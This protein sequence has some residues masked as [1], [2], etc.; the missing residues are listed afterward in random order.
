[1]LSTVKP[2]IAS[3]DPGKTGALALINGD[4]DLVDLVDMPISTWK[5]KK[6][7]IFKAGQVVETYEEDW[8]FDRAGIKELLENWR[9]LYSVDILYVEKLQARPDISGHAAILMGFNAG[10]V[11]GS[12]EALGYQVNE[13]TPQTWKKAMCVTAD[14]KTSLKAVRDRWP[15]D[16]RFKFEKHH[17]RAEAALI[18]LYGLQHGG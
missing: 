17:N 16:P 13:V 1:M 12:G 8:A 9:L 5:G 15:V 11:Q 3:C 2:F 7:L 14:K 4:G 10:L 6:K 18:G